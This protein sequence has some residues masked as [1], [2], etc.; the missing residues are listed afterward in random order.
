MSLEIDSPATKVLSPEW[1]FIDDAAHELRTPITIISGYVDL[2]SHWGKND[3]ATLTEGLH[4]IKT[5]TEYMSQLIQRLLFL[6]RTN[7]KNLTSHFSLI[8][9]ADL[10][11]EIYETAMLV[12]DCHTILLG[13]H[14]EAYFC[15]DPGSVKEMLRIFLDN[16]LKYTPDD[17]MVFLSNYTADKN[18]YIQIKD[19][20]IGIR[21]E[22]IDHV[23][24]RSYR[25][26]PADAPL[27]ATTNGS[28][29]GLSIAQYIAK[30]NKAII[31]I[32]SQP[33]T[34]TTIT[35]RF[36]LAE[37]TQTPSDNYV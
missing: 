31:D 34:G 36:P 17:G 32:T 37:K 13:T 15:A 10:L 26:Y 33:G 12:P 22:D 8:N 6:A 21:P 4:T 28:G 18:V 16:A 1:Q 35:V 27:P 14:E 25:S 3:P 30:E 24:E 29:L 5:E 23:F 19:T 2:L 9:A 20:G 7:K 11:T